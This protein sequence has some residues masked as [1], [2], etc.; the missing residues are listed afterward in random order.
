MDAGIV[1]KAVVLYNADDAAK[2]VARY[3]VETNPSLPTI[4]AAKSRLETAKH[5]LDT[6]VANR[7]EWRHSRVQPFNEAIENA[8]TAISMLRVLHPGDVGLKVAADGVNRIGRVD[9]GWFGATPN[10]AA[11]V[12]AHVEGVLAD[13]ESGRLLV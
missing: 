10:R 11:Q 4:S 8:R 12:R 7:F 6:V 13:I 9:T 5:R 3:A 1:G 2:S